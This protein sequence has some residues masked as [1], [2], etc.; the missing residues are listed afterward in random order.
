MA[1]SDIP[2]YRQHFK[3]SDASTDFYDAGVFKDQSAFGSDLTIDAGTPGF[4]TVGSGRGMTLDNTCQG[5]FLPCNPWEGWV[6]AVMKP[7]MGSNGTIY[8]VI[9]GQAVSIASNGSIRIVRGGATNYQHRL[10]TP[11]AGVTNSCAYTDNGVKVCAFSLSQETRI[12][13][14][15]PDGVTVTAG[16][17]VADGGNGNALAWGWANGPDTL[18]Q[19]ARFGNIVGTVGSV[20]VST[21]T[22]VMCELILGVGNPLVGDGLAIVETEMAAL[23]AEYT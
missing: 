7:N 14:S 21:N 6:I 19:T 23:A 20:T 1:I 17:A 3:F 5:R 22:M 9:L 10:A 18:G 4:V 15:T 11:S 8:P 13:Y 12:G 2:G 16:S